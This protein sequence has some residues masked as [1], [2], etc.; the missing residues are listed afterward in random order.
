MKSGALRRA[1]GLVLLY[2]GIFTVLVLA[3]FSR[4]AGFSE[5]FGRLTVSAAYPKAE[6]GNIARGTA[7]VPARA[8]PLS[9]RIACAGLVLIV[10][11]DS[12]AELVAADGST[13]SL[14]LASVDRLPNGARVRFE[15]GVELRATA[16]RSQGER[17][18]LEASGPAGAASIR[19]RY[20]LSGRL[21][22][23]SK[24]GAARLESA[25]GPWELSLPAASLKSERGILQLDAREGG[26]GG[27]AL[28]RAAPAGTPAARV[29]A[30][31]R[32]EQFIAQAP[33]DA[34]TFKAEIAAWRDKAWSGLSSGRWDGER[35]AWRGQDGSPAFTEKALAAYLAESLARGSYPDALARAKLGRDRWPDRLS[36]VTAPFLGGLVPRMQALETADLI[37]VKRL[38]QLVQDRSPELFA[39]ES[40]LHFLLDRSPFALAQDAL[41]LA[42]ELD[43]AKLGVRHAIGLLGCV[44]ESRSYLKDEENPFLKLGGAADRV[45]AAVRK[46]SDGFFVATEEDGSTDLRLSLLA[47]AYLVDFGAGTGKDMLVGVGQSLVEGVI[48]LADDQGFAPAK[49]L[50]RSGSLG[51]RTGVLAPEEIYPLFAG[52][53]Y[54]PREVSFY[55]DVA[56]GVWAWTCAPQMTVQAQASRYVF[57]VSFPEGRAHYMAFYGIKQFA[58][59]QLYNIDYSPD[60]EFEIYDASGYLYRKPSGALYMKMK[61]KSASEDIKLFF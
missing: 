24:D 16:D 53:P 38:T 46:S 25:G 44:A 17:Y 28:R 35:V 31:P 9:A 34:A 50:V 27:L 20:S 33:K 60:A 47:G 3:Q 12:P 43:P 22:L 37:E 21:A 36:F 14:P 6:R 15:G 56:P 61:H 26:F 11:A 7:P 55:R 57:T 42:A 10:S 8:A 59:I 52:N 48:G 32:Q 13:K 2:I 19:L 54:Y 41:R 39:K 58:N 49:A 51:Q 18:S 30:K 23:G 5:R 40:L 1:F 4:G 45:V 29:A